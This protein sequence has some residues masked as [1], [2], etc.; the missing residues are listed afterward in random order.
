MFQNGSQR[1]ED[2]YEPKYFGD[3]IGHKETIASLREYAVQGV[4]TTPHMIF[5]GGFGLGK[6]TL[7]KA[8][9][10]E[11]G[12]NYDLFSASDYRNVEFMQKLVKDLD[13][14][15]KVDL[16]NYEVLENE[17]GSVF[18]KH[19]QRRGKL[20]ILD[21]FDSVSPEAQYA[22]KEVLIPAR[23]YTLNRVIITTNHMEKIIQDL[24]Q[25]GRLKVLVFNPVSISE[26]VEYGRKIMTAYGKGINENDLE[27]IA[28]EAHG[29]PRFLLN[30]LQDYREGNR[31]PREVRD[32][33]EL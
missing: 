28:A 12:A 18:A 4:E 19:K 33:F 13:V 23:Q 5:Y 21:D 22:L 16:E 31:Y 17:D 9:A 6:T 15:F 1:L 25:S 2:T 11:L 30:S 3:F 24:S 20:F 7:A 29:S 26:L 27:R 14:S 32:V 8:V 10:R